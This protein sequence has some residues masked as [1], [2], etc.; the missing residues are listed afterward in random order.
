MSTFILEIG[1]GST[2]SAG[3]L[4]P[5]HVGTFPSRESAEAWAERVVFNGNWSVLNPLLPGVVEGVLQSKRG[6]V[7]DLGSFAAYVTGP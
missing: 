3:N 7:V 6:E 1:A 4:V 5:R 2:D